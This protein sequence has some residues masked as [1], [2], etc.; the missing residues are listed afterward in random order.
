MSDENSSGNQGDC[1]HVSDDGSAIK[2]DDKEYDLVPASYWLSLGYSEYA[3]NT[4]MLNFQINMH[5]M[6][7]EIMYGEGTCA[8]CGAKC[9][10]L[11]VSME[12]SYDAHGNLPENEAYTKPFFV[13]YDDILRHEWQLTMDVLSEF[14]GPIT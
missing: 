2:Y 14:T 1:F 5:K 3:A 12:Q 13:K 7:R 8:E 10:A 6:R 11:S 4:I 9:S